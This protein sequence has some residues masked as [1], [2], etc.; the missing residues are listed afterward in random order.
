MTCFG[1]VLAGCGVCSGNPAW[2]GTGLGI[3]D[4]VGG[5]ANGGSEPS[6]GL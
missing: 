2:K 3:A 1:A 5:I 6:T 4:A